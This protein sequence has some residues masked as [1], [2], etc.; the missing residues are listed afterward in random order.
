MLGLW[1]DRLWRLPN[2]SGVRGRGDYYKYLDDTEDT[3]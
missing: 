1:E 2:L 3:F